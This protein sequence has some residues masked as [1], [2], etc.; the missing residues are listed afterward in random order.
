M[1]RRNRKM[2]GGFLDSLTNSLSSGWSSFTQTAANAY[3]K[4][5]NAITGTTNNSY[6]YGYT[7]IP[8]NTYGTSNNYGY[9]G[10]QYQPAY[11]VGGRTRKN[12]RG[13]SYVASKPS[14]ALSSGAA[15]VSNVKTA[16]PHNI[17]GGKK[18][19]RYRKRTH[20]HTKTCKH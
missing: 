15:P 19:M 14:T 9:T 11:S 13:G 1:P 10:N 18:S 5:K 7:G 12:K 8:S 20:K 3:N 2:K 6:G 17:V 16:L 4:T